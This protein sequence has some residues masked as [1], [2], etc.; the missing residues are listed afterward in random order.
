ME[1]KH[2]SNLLH[3]PTQN[4]DRDL[5]KVILRIIKENNGIAEWKLILNKTQRNYWKENY[6]I[7]TD[8]V[9]K[10]Q[11][12]LLEKEDKLIRKD[13]FP[14]IHYILTPSGHTI[15]DPLHV[16]LWKFF[17]YDKNNAL[18]LVSTAISLGSLVVAIVALSN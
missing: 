3:D 12:D 17:V 15:F 4:M 5:Q 13:Q 8:V 9:V 6:P 18:V 16:R 7:E 1:L 11:M 10:H 2:S 14:E